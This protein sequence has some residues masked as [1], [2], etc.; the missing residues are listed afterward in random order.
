[1]QGA[2]VQSLVRG[3]RLPLSAVRERGEKNTS[4]VNSKPTSIT[5]F[6]LNY[7]FKDYLQIHSYWGIRV[8]VY[9]FWRYNSFC[10]KLQKGKCES[11]KQKGWTEPLVE[12]S[13]GARSTEEASVDFTHW[14]SQLIL[15][16]CSISASLP[17]GSWPFLVQIL[18][19]YPKGNLGH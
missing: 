19:F 10:H 11:G 13:G 16:W 8:T 9:E 14:F 6:N 12:N 1:M 5:S 2:Q 17:G 7:I 3:L 18:F 15:M 4:L